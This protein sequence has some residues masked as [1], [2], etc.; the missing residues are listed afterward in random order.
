MN[1]VARPWIGLC[2]KLMAL[3]AAIF[4]FHLF[5]AMDEDRSPES[6]TTRFRHRITG[7]VTE[8]KLD[9][10]VYEGRRGRTRSQD[11]QYLFVRFDPDSKVKYADFPDKVKEAD[12]PSA[13]AL[14]GDPAKD[15]KYVELMS[16]PRALYD[17]TKVGDVLTVVDAPFSGFGPERFPISAAS[18]PA[19]P[20]QDGDC[21]ALALLLWLIGWRISKASA[22]R[23]IIEVTKIPGVRP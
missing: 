21:L 20:I 16:V 17:R 14:T 6:A 5:H 11:V 12:L 8:M 4:A 15:G 19:K 1:A 3:L 2:F 23:G 13:P 10:V 22:L 9:K 18:I 7:V